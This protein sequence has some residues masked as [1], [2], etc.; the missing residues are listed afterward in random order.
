MKIRIISDIHLEFMK[1]DE[2][3]V[4]LILPV[5]PDDKETVLILAGDIGLIKKPNGIRVFF[6]NIQHRFKKILYVLGNHEY[7][8]G[9]FISSVTAHSSLCDDYGI[10]LMENKSIV[11]DGIKF[12]GAT[13]WT[14]FNN[15]NPNDKI[16]A[17]L[18]MNDFRVIRTGD[19][20]QTP[21][22][23]YARKLTP[24]DTVITHTKSLKYIVGELKT[25]LKTVVITH[26]APSYSSIHDRYKGSNINHA[27]YSNLDEI[28]YQD[29][30]PVLWVHGH[31]HDSFDYKIHNTRVIVNPRGYHPS[32]TNPKYDPTLVIEV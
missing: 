5:L 9:S 2:I 10:V 32:D 8:G 30:S 14:N 28:M 15:D 18:Y 31:M 3:D 19:K 27:Y 12:I 21:A 13:L 11:I 26:H 25:D 17:Q 6:E 22:D 24:A 20:I 4:P 23:T 7:Y 1:V 16:V 29:Y